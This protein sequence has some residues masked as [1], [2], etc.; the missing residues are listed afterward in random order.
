MIPKEPL[1]ANTRY[2][3][4]VVASFPEA[5]S[6]S[7][8]TAAVSFTTGDSELADETLR[9]PPFTTASFL[10]GAPD[11]GGPRVAMACIGGLER[12]SPKDHELIAWHGDKILMRTTSYVRAVGN[13]GLD[14]VPDCIELRRRAPDGRRSETTKICGAD[15]LTR[16]FQQTD[17]TDDWVPCKGGILGDP[18]VYN[19]DADAGVVTEPQR[20]GLQ[21]RCSVFGACN[22]SNSRSG[23][24]MVVMSR[25]MSGESLTSQA[26]SV[27]RTRM[28]ASRV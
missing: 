10:R 20:P 5:L 4:R 16:D 6:S 18:S 1:A 9:P 15:L 3:I 25:A 7:Q 17:L 26:S 8:Q 23:R 27:S 11:C 12:Q 2:T 19:D 21:R 13:Y 28:H 24:A 14:E 22:Y